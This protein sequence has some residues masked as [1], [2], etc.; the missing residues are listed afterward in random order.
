MPKASGRLDRWS[1]PSAVMIWV[2]TVAVCLAGLVV[3]GLT[4]AHVAADP[5]ACAVRNELLLE[6]LDHVGV[7]DPKSAAAVWAEG[8][9]L[10]NAA[11]QFSVMDFDLRA[12]HMAR[13]ESTFPNW[14]T[15]V[16]SPWIEGYELL[17]TTPLGDA[18]AE[19]ELK[20]ATATSTGAAGSYHATL[21]VE[22]DGAFWRVARIDADE[23][24]SAYTGF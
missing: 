8:L 15:G 9:R 13:L 3:P 20:F 14:V 22:R 6:A 23:G 1:T 11:L 5:G 12:E 18:R 16:S 10:R 17:R 2:I 19:I 21:T 7:C 4:R 24:L